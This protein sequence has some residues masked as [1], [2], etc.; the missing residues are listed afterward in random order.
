MIIMRK[1]KR[2]ADGFMQLTSL[3]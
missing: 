1:D 2:F 3:K